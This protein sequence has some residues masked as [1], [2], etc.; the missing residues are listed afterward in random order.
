[1][2]P[3][4]SA[5]KW[6]LIYF[7]KEYFSMQIKLSSLGDLMFAGSNERGQQ[8]SFSGNKEAVS[9]MESVLMAA[10][11]CSAIDVEILL[12]K[13]RQPYTRIEVET[14]GV[15]AD[16]IPAV[17][18][19]IHLHYKIYGDVKPEKAEKAVAMSLEKYCSVSLM[20]SASVQIS[21]S[22]EVVRE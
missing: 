16:T 9:P 13:M 4:A 19:T 21:H 18:Q 20:L 14:E 17:F 6:L 11:A 12:Q 7:R 10:A 5:V 8:I 2:I 22:V 3:L 1:M 15:R